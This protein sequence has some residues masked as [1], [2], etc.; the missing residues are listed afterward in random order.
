MKLVIHPPVEPERLTQIRA[1]AGDMAVVNA[2]D[3][4]EAI[5]AI[6]DADAF[7]GKL[8]PALLAAARRLR[9]VQAPT[10]SLEH[11]VFPEL[12][13]HPVTLTNMRGLFS[14]VIADHVFGYI[15]C[16]A[17]N[18]HRY[19]RNQLAARWEAVGGEAARSTF[20]AGP[21]RVSA[22][23]RAHLHLADTTLGVVGLGQIGSEIARR[24]LAF[25]MRVVAVDPARTQAPAGVAALW[26]PDR[27]PDLLGES[28]F[29]VVAAPHT[30]ETYK[31]FRSAQFRQMKPTA[32]FINIG[33]GAIVDLA[34]LTAALQAGELAGAGLDVYEVEP[35][36]A[37]HPLWRLENVILTPHVAGASPRIAE[38]HLAVLLRNIRH[39][40][41]G[42]PLENVADKAAWF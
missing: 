2:R 8:T 32:Y 40:V 10:V 21:G 17:R 7:F 14:D 38:R 4:A 12:V 37:E 16:F 31:L 22:M 42:E 35:L 19:I 28:D 6:A 27:L 41:R 18:F 1:A 25:G 34:D 11:Y 13:S 24:G 39:F 36:P 5:R 9:W 29:V 23:D 3:E 26:K 20:A 33:R 15:I 30:P